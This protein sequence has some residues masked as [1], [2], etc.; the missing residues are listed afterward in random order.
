MSPLARTF[1]DR[2]N[3]RAMPGEDEAKGDVALIRTGI[4]R[5]VD[6][7]QLDKPGPPIG[8]RRGSTVRSKSYAARHPLKAGSRGEPDGGAWITRDNQAS[9][10][11]RRSR[12]QAEAKP[13][14]AVGRDD[15][16]FSIVPLVGERFKVGR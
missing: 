10:A 11:A 15:M 3:Q 13:C 1:P 6:R 12:A 14:C 16:V 4:E 2:A 9:G 7:E 8:G 5:I